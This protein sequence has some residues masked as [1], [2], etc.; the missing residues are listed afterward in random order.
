MS[1]L[2]YDMADALR[3]LDYNQP[4]M[5][6]QAKYDLA[7]KIATGKD[8]ERKKGKLSD[9]LQNIGKSGN[10]YRTMMSP[11][12]EEAA[13]YMA[14]KPDQR[15]ALLAAQGQAMRQKQQQDGTFTN[16]DMVP[17]QVAGIRG[18][19]GGGMDMNTPEGMTN[20]YSKAA[21]ISPEAADITK[22]IM[23]MNQPAEE[24]KDIVMAKTLYPE[25]PL[26]EAYQKMKS[27]GKEDDRLQKLSEN[28]QKEIDKA[29]K[30][31]EDYPLEYYNK[32]NRAI[33]TYEPLFNK[34][35]ISVKSHPDYEEF[36]KGYGE[37]KRYSDFED[38]WKIAK[39]SGDIEKVNALIADYAAGIEGT[40]TG[41]MPKVGEIIKGHRFKGGDPSKREN[42]EK[43]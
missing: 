16:E 20:L 17:Y 8:E 34:V 36:M 1:D 11:P 24:P 40:T 5:P 41:N 4:D 10:P 43:Q 42:W 37:Q 35:G 21:Q 39:E 25:L 15:N 23:S 19:A 13:Q 29:T 22:N 2:E 33:E 6:K 18:P 9:L 7:Y 32:V 31:K 14:D 27:V 26:A 38:K 3:D 12:Q 28:Y 30:L